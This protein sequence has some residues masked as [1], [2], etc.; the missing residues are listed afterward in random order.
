MV[1]GLELLQSCNGGWIT[2][3]HRVEYCHFIFFNGW[4]FSFIYLL[5]FTFMFVLSF[6]EVVP[7]P[8]FLWEVLSF[9]CFHVFLSLLS[10]YNVHYLEVC[11]MESLR[12]IR[13]AMMEW[14]SSSLR[15]LV[16]WYIH[17]TLHLRVVILDLSLSLYIVKGVKKEDP[18]LNEMNSQGGWNVKVDH[19]PI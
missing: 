17:L 6:L 14:S 1:W 12:W 4:R 19:F 5:L 8:I 10:L 7:F 13:V 16:H 11:L 18:K 3:T 9:I 2:S 15:I